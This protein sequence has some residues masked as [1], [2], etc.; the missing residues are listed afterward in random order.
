MGNG[1]LM[2]DQQNGVI[3]DVMANS[4]TKGAGDMNSNYQWQ[5]HQ[6]N[7]RVQAHLREAAEHRR[8]K[9]AN[10]QSLA[11]APWKMMI[12]ILVGVAVAL[13]LLTSCANYNEPVGKVEASA[14]H[15]SQTTMAER[16]RFQDKRDENLLL[17]RDA[18]R[19]A[20]WTMAERIRFQDKRGESQLVS[21]DSSHAAGWIIA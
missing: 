6:A 16:I 12:P 19:A 9:Q 21:R 5:K 18:Y 4:P 3:V 7:E 8:V 1:L 15:A 20:R 13:W 2:P 17:S 11:P 14:Y 10:S